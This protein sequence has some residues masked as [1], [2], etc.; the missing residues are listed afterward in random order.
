MTDA[1][2]SD[3]KQLNYL[4]TPAAWSSHPRYG[5]SSTEKYYM[6]IPQQIFRV[7]SGYDGAVWLR[8][9]LAHAVQKKSGM[10]FVQNKE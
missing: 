7:V 4:T 3:V 8:L 10:S 1:G 5:V 6:R 2:C 9:R